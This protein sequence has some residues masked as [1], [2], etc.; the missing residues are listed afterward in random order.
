MDVH[1]KDRC[2]SLKNEDYNSGNAADWQLRNPSISLVSGNPSAM[3]Q[4][5]QRGSSSCS[6]LPMDDPFSTGLWNLSTKSTELDLCK[7]NSPGNSN[8]ITGNSGFNVEWN[9]SESMSIGV[10]GALLQASAGILHPSLSHFPADSG[11]IERAA[12][13]SSFSTSNVGGVMNPFSL[14]QPQNAYADASRDDSGAQIQKNE[15]NMME[16]AKK[17]SFS[18]D[19]GSKNDSPMKEQKEK[20]NLY[21]VARQEGQTNLATSAGNSSS[22]ELGTTKRKRSNEDMTLEQAKVAPQIS[23]EREEE[24]AEFEHNNEQNS[25]AVAS[26]KPKGKQVKDSNESSKDD[27]IHIRARRGQATNSHSLAERVRREKINERMKLLQDLVPGCSKVTG[28]AVMLDEIINYVQS[29][30]QQ[31]EFLS[32]KLAA[33]NPRL[34]IDIDAVLS[35]YLLQPCNGPVPAIGFPSNIIHPPLHPSQQGLVQAGLSGIVNPP[36]LVRRSI[37]AQLTA[38][39][40]YKESKMQVPNAWDEEL[41]NSMQMSYNN[42][43][44]LNAHRPQQ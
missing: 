13:F 10:G 14:A 18:T 30:Q 6:T 31:V 33:I 36:D 7:N 25:S 1:E 37:D 17:A 2:D 40:G 28:K 11:F 41:H 34:D 44:N 4:R 19:H 35:K 32:M 27:F 16:A 23:G 8:P 3:S 9:S 21:G 39:Q 43:M 42:N 20:D 5:N 22:N 12:R 26:V 24:N 38:I 15:I 29:L